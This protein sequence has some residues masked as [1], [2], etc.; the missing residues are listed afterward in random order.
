MTVTIRNLRESDEARWRELWLGYLD[1][2]QHPNLPPKVT[3]NTWA[4]LTGERPDVFG[5]VAESADG[6]V[7]G[8]THGVVHANT[9]IDEPICYLEDLFVDPNAR[10]NG[11]GNALIEAMIARA[12]KQNWGQ[13]YWRTGDDN[14]AR[15]LYDQVAKKIDFVTYV[16]TLGPKTA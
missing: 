14:P 9:W 8:F 10:R 6:E 1:W 13:V 15:A 16:R 2:Y 4:M 3:S 12:D 11:A 7:V 5:L